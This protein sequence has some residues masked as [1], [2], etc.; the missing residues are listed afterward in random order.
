MLHPIS[1]MY[2]FRYMRTQKWRSGLH[3]ITHMESGLVKTCETWSLLII[4]RQ[5]SWRLMRP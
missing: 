5:R 3:H 2:I 4:S 1:N